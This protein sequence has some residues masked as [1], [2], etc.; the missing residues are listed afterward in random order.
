MPFHAPLVIV[1]T[2]VRDEVTTFGASALPVNVPAGA[3]TALVPAALINPF[4]LTVKLGMA[5]DVPK[6]PALL[7]TVA[8]VRA[9][10]DTSAASPETLSG[11][12]TVP[13]LFPIGICPGP[14]A[15]AD[16]VP[17]FVAATVPVTLA[18]VP[19]VF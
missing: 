13:P 4:A 9:P 2:V 12:Y 1:P 7:L 6:L 14:G 18:A 15:A 16:P 11:A 19:V 8:S 17:P 10:E 5:V 3:T